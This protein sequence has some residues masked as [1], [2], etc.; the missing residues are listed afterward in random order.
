MAGS[1]T[2]WATG[3]LLL[4]CAALGGVVAVELVEG[5]PLAPA[6]TAASPTRGAHEPPG[7]PAEF[8]PPPRRQFHV[9]ADRPLFSKS[10][11]PW[12]APPPP[13]VEQAKGPIAVATPVELVGVLLTDQGGSALLLAGGETKAS[14]VRQ[15]E[16]FLGWQI[17]SIERDWVELRQGDRTE[18][19][20]LRDD[21]SVGAAAR[22]PARPLRPAKKSA[23]K[24]EKLQP[25]AKANGVPAEK[26][27]PG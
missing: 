15:G 11:R 9:T 25:P 8:Q 14:W 18:I 3:L 10:R 4:T 5:L 19:V 24:D 23:A 6:V 13:K 27:A 20:E 7:A 16:V 2:G 21:D 22:R 1:R 12:M 26:P 17:E